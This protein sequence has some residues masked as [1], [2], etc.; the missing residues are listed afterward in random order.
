MCPSFLLQTAFAYGHIIICSWWACI[1]HSLS[2]ETT[3]SLAMHY[4][5]CA[6]SLQPQLFAH[7]AEWETHLLLLLLKSEQQSALRLTKK[8][9]SF[10]VSDVMRALLWFFN[11]LGGAFRRVF[12]S[13]THANA[14]W[15]N[16]FAL[17]IGERNWCERALLRNI[18]SK[19]CY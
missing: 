1:M 6:V 9:A 2:A 4:I 11:F 17:I 3:H 16:F 19:K 14:E 8:K 15:Q 5:A 13:S 7:V 12:D 18:L 10:F